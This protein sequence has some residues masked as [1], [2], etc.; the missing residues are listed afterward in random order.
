MFNLSNKF[1]GDTF[2]WST[3][4]KRCG[5]LC[6]YA[7]GLTGKFLT[8]VSWFYEQPQQLY[9]DVEFPSYRNIV[10]RRPWGLELS[11]LLVGCGFGFFFCLFYV[12]GWTR[13]LFYH[14]NNNNNNDN[15]T[16]AIKLINSHGMCQ[17]A[18]NQI[19]LPCDVSVSDRSECL[20]GGF[21]AGL[22]SAALF[23]LCI[24]NR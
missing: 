7:S 18:E 10:K 15:D 3:F 23:D 9:N 5:H 4:V 17:S 24:R 22:L 14:K 13:L 6:T 21:V 16:T 8:S 2:L 19:K 11:W 1:H 20:W 12:S